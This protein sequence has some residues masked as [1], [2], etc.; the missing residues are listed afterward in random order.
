[1]ALSED[2]LENEMLEDLDYLYQLYRKELEK[3]KSSVKSLNILI[4]A[5]K[6]AHKYYSTDEETNQEIKPEN[7]N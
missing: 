3:K 7:E 4:R 2:E 1:M 6:H 5:L